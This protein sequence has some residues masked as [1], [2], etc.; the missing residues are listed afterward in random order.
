MVRNS[1]QLHSSGV[2]SDGRGDRTRASGDGPAASHFIND[3]FSAS[4]GGGAGTEYRDGPGNGRGG[5]KMPFDLELQPR[6]R[7]DC[8]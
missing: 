1:Q 4:G 5:G 2:R 3:T 7:E 6:E 8:R